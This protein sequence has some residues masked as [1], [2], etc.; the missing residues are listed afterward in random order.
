V[1]S[2]ITKAKGRISSEEFCGR[3]ISPGKLETCW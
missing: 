1:R 2:S 3:A